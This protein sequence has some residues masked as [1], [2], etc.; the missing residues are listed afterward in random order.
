MKLLVLSAFVK[1]L[2]YLSVLICVASHVYIHCVYIQMP[3]YVLSLR[4]EL[5]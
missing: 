5:Q 4:V 2:C 3:E 1:L